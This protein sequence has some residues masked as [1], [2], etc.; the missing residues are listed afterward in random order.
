MS[1]GARMLSGNL[2]YAS[3]TAGLAKCLIIPGRGDFG[4]PV[5]VAGS[6]VALDLFIEASRPRIVRTTCESYRDRRAE[7]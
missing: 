5:E 1:A 7:A 4:Q 6:G 2:A 3:Q